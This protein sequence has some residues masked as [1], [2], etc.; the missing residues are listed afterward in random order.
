MEPEIG[1]CVGRGSRQE[2]DIDKRIIERK[3]KGRQPTR[4]LS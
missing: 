1:N 3:K 2:R 4:S